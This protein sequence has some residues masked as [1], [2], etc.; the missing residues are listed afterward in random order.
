VPR[1]HERQNRCDDEQNPATHARSMTEHDRA[2]VFDMDG[3]LIDSEPLWRRAEIEVFATVGLELSQ[4]DCIRTQG[5]RMDEAA[6]YWFER[7]PWA[8]PG[9]VEIAE[10]V[11]DRMVGLVQNE[12]APM[13]GARDSLAAAQEAGWRIGLASSS[14][15]RLIETVLDRFDLRDCFEVIRSAEQEPRG[16]PH[17]DVYLSTLRDLRIEGIDSVAVE[18]S[19]NGVTSAIAAGMRCIAVPPP[20]TSADP[21]FETASWRLDSL[22]ELPQALS[23]IETE[24]NDR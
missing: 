6:L 2:L 20:E 24:R 15:T 21:R 18:D 7:S 3:V 19:A 1:S 13:T 5:L 11:V 4:A 17:P 8:G 10:A 22:E 23:K 9:P 14:S 12:A 16:K